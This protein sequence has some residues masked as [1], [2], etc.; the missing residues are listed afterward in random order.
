MAITV[1]VRGHKEVS[2]QIA[3]L[4]RVIPQVT[5]Q[6]LIRNVIYRAKR[7]AKKL[8]PI[9]WTGRTRRGW[10]TRKVYNG[11]NLYNELPAMRFIDQ[12]TK[13]HG[14]VTA[15]FLYIPLNKKASRG[16]RPGLVRGKDYVL[17][18][19]V[20]GIRAMRIAGFVRKRAREWFVSSMERELNRLIQ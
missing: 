7:L 11:Y 5:R 1:K 19:R 6:R 10:R 16:W 4:S 15:K 17:K 20:R 13:A 12:G 8:T 3:R 2:R 18:K 14:P 9:R